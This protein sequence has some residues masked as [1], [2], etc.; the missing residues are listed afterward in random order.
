MIEADLDRRYFTS[1][2]MIHYRPNSVNVLRL[3]PQP[4][5]TDP[6]APKPAIA[7][8][9][10]TERAK[11]SLALKRDTFP[12]HKHRWLKIADWNPKD[13]IDR[14]RARCAAC[15]REKILPAADVIVSGKGW[16]GGTGVK[17]E[18]LAQGRGLADAAGK[19]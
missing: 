14:I 12:D 3:A 8:D 17:P 16:W 4:P 6:K 5:D 7:A 18:R 9:S 10:P 11:R 2:P 1:G 15:K 19:T 13:G